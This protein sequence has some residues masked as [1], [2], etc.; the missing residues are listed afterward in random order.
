MEEQIRKLARSSYWQ[1][2]YRN[3]KNLN[4]SL[5]FNNNNFSGIQVLFLY[6]LK[7]YDLLYQ[8][9]ADQEWNNLNE[10]VIKNNFRCDA[11]LYYRQKEIEKKI[12]KNKQEEKKLGRKNKGN[13]TNYPI[14]KGPKGKGNS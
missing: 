14:Y 13:L 3:S 1:S 6:W 2:L 9:L 11:F 10:N 4:L 12:R 8:E 7:I 5:F